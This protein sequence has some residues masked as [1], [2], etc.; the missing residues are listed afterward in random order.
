MRS[1]IL[2]EKQVLKIVTLVNYIIIMSFNASK[3]VLS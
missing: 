1:N 3:W 2:L